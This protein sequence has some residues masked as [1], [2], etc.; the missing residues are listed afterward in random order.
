MGG[1]FKENEEVLKKFFFFFL[2]KCVKIGRA[3]LYGRTHLIIQL[4]EHLCT[5]YYLQRRRVH[6]LKG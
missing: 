6:R 5:K 4:A 2:V 1:R 3:S